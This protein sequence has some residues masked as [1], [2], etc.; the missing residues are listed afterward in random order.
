MSEELKFIRGALAA[1]VVFVFIVL[2]IIFVA[3]VG[4]QVL[5]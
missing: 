2:A 5:L 1:I 3:W 4:K